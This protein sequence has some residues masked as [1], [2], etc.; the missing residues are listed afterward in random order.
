MRFKMPGGYVI[1]PGPDLA[2]TFSPPLNTTSNAF[3]ECAAGISQPVVTPAV[4]A[5]V[6][7]N[8]R[9][10]RVDTIVVPRDQHGWRCVTT[11]LTGALGPSVS[12]DGSYVWASLWSRPWMGRG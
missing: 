2:A 6:H 7:A 3:F 9:A 1:S 10:W 11:F 12:E 5:Q 4:A 8:L